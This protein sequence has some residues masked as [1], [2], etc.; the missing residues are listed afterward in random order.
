[1]PQLIF[2]LVLAHSILIG[3][4]SF[5]VRSVSEVPFLKRAMTQK[6]GGIEV[7]VAVPNREETRQLF[8]VDLYARGVQPVWL[9]IE[10][11]E[12]LDYLFFPLNLDPDYF[13]ANEAAWMHRFFLS[14]TAN[15][16]MA[17]HFQSQ[18][19]NLY[20]RH[21]G[22]TQ[23]FVFTNKKDGVK[24]VN[25]ELFGANSSH[26]FEFILPVPGL[27]FD[28]EQVDFDRLYPERDVQNFDKAADMRAYLEQLPCCVFGPDQKTPG[29]PLN[30][31]VVGSSE[32][33]V[34]AFIS[35][36]WDLTEQL[37]AGSVWQTVMSSLF[38]SFYS[39]AP[40][41]SLYLFGRRQD[42]ALQKARNTVDERN[43]LR[44]WMAPVR[45]RGMPV[46]VGQISRDIGVRFSSRTFVTH[47]IDPD[48]DE[49]R[50]Y[51][52]QD[53]LN[54]RSVRAVGHT[55][56][57][58]K[59]QPESPRYNYTRDPYFTDGLRVVLILSPEP[60]M[61]EKV[62]RLPWADPVSP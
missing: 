60:V 36:G 42:F 30:L 7:T 33:V 43:H 59:A 61:I 21:G 51:L 44:L 62:E 9:R 29:D 54:A 32:D 48:V 14:E 26:R 17:N 18:Q 25:V 22:N 39:N 6:K 23:G 10:N 38:R 56:G 8:G 37:H 41:S 2:C 1:M 11:S 34:S 3:C 57:V 13:S 45:Y 55:E 15:R 58:G 40:V 16:Q 27:K 19:P 4:A 53:L 20:I 12:N 28:F 35:R 46:L 5:Q 47:K 24:F 31:V 49:T 50:G 52:V